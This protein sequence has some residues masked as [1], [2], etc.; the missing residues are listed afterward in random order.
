[1]LFQF[2]VDMAYRVVSGKS[3]QLEDVRENDE[4][5]KQK[6]QNNDLRSVMALMWSE[7]KKCRKN[8]AYLAKH[9]SLFILA[10]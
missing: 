3:R 7:R 8:C 10:R 9:L 4:Q 2:I 1:M 6:A 5:H